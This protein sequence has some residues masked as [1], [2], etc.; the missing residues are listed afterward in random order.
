MV[1]APHPKNVPAM[2]VTRVRLVMSQCVRILVNTEAA[3]LPAPVAVK[4]ALLERIA[5]FHSVNLVAVCM[6]LA[7]WSM[8]VPVHLVG[9]EC[10]ALNQYVPQP[11]E[12]MELAHLLILALVQLDTRELIVPSPSAPEDVIMVCVRHL[13][14]VHARWDGRISPAPRLFA[15]HHV[16]MGSALVPTL[17]SVKP[18]TKAPIVSMPFVAAV[19][20]EVVLPLSN[21]T[22]IL[23][24]W[25]LIAAKPAVFLLA[26]LRAR[27]LYP[28]SAAARRVSKVHFVR[29]PFVNMAVVRMELAPIL[30]RAAVR[31]DGLE[32]PVVEPFAPLPAVMVLALHPI[33]VRVKK[34]TRALPVRCQSVKPVSMATVLPPI[35]VSVTMDGLMLRVQAIARNPFVMIPPALPQAVVSLLIPVTVLLD[36]MVWLVRNPFAV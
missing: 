22:A 11:V 15:T 32:L 8:P 16:V 27:V 36:G 2:P 33:T 25:V 34:V 13:A 20:M 28:I 26:A 7:L 17:A 24:G 23:D 21:A 10:H 9:A 35:P 1:T 4:M 5:P 18:A 30:T 31:L 12:N 29:N 14:I 19:P 6:V 3:F